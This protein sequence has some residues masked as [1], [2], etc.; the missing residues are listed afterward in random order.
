[1]STPF[2]AAGAKEKGQTE[3]L[4]GVISDLKGVISDPKR[5]SSLYPRT[6]RNHQRTTRE[7][8]TRASG[9]RKANGE[10]SYSPEFER[11]WSLHRRGGKPAAFKAYLKAVPDKI[12]HEDA[13]EHLLAYLDSRRDGFRGAHL[14]TWLNQ[15]YWEQDLEDDEPEA[16]RL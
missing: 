15:E 13:E 8:P 10:G 16:Y 5:G 11:L 4:K 14:S 2:E 6:V 1:M 9:E 7:P 3:T 12:S